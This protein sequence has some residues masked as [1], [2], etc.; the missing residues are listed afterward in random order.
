MCVCVRVCVF[1]Y[2]L[3]LLLCYF[4][5]FRCACMCVGMCRHMCVFQYSSLLQ[6]H[7]IVDFSRDL[8]VRVCVCV[9]VCLC[10]YVGVCKCGC[11]CMCIWM[12]VSV[13]CFPSSLRHHCILLILAMWFCVCMWVCV[14]G[15]MCMWVGVCVCKRVPGYSPNRSDINSSQKSAF[16]QIPGKC[17]S[18]RQMDRL[19][20]L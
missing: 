11:V 8:C 7:Y 15:C 9:C 1:C 4:I 16:S 13:F 3:S 5:Y 6:L 14:Y 18:N 2:P 12:Y 20:L 10:V 19:T 17:I